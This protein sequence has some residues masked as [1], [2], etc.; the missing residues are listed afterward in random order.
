LASLL[1]A[2]LLQ[3]L[4]DMRYLESAAVLVVRGGPTREPVVPTPA[5][6][7]ERR[8]LDTVRQDFWLALVAAQLGE[9]VGWSSLQDGRLFNDVVP[10]AG[11]EHSQTGHG[12]LAALGLHVE[13]GFSDDRCDA[14]ALLCMR[15]GDGAAS[16]VATV[17]ALDLTRLDLDILFAPCF[18]IRPDPEHLRDVQVGV[19]NQPRAVL[20]G[21]PGAPYL[22]VDPAYTEALPGHKCADRALDELCRQ[23]AAALIS[24][25]LDTGDLIL[26]D[27]FRAVHGRASFVP[28]YDGTDRWLRK[29]TVLR[30]LRRTRRS[31]FDVDA[32]II[33][34]F[35]SAGTARR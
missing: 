18:Y 19:D 21:D 28:R 8:P 11:E 3:T 1:P 20:F 25:H 29:L 17:A 15:N 30:D 35:A 16:T 10:I 12:S 31:R 32:R 24:V 9:P 22:R 2:T 7:R 33:D 4:I 14:L 13:D 26:I 34:A 6:W 5:H 23:L 27:N